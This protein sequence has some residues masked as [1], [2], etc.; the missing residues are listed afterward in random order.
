MRRTLQQRV[1]IEFNTHLSIWMSDNGC[2]HNNPIFDAVIPKDA[3]SAGY[4]VLSVRFKNFL[5]IGTFECGEDMR[6]Q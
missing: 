6:M 1:N 2:N 5:S 4:P 3:V